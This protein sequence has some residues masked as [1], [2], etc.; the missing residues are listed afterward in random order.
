M[1]LAEILSDLTS[2]RIC[3]P[4]A[5]L[6]LV[7]A[8]TRTSK[9]QS[10]SQSQSPDAEDA[11]LKRAKELVE[12]HYGVKEKHR[13]GELGNGLEDARRAVERAVGF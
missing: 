1:Q 7:S 2:L 3:D 12:M 8:G 9:S 13:R 10:Q 4:A 11:E 5:A 6:A